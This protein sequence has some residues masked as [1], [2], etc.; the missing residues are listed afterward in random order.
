MHGPSLRDAHKDVVRDLVPH[1][2]GTRRERV[3]DLRD[4]GSKI[5]FV[6]ALD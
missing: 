5:V 2:G 6:R 3:L 4:H 1:R